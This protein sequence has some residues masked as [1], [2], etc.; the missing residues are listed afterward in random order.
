MM[1]EKV[2]MGWYL[3]SFGLLIVVRKMDWLWE[4]QVPELSATSHLKEAELR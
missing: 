2:V 4:L 1:K 3:V